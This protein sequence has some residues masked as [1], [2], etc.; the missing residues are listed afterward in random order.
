[1]IQPHVANTDG[2]LPIGFHANPGNPPVRGGGG[3]GPNPTT[4]AKW[5]AIN[6]T[7]QVNPGY[8]ADQSAGA[9]TV[10]DTGTCLALCAGD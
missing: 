1:M 2:W 9:A 3:P 10:M 5:G 7:P 4:Y 8:T 6:Y